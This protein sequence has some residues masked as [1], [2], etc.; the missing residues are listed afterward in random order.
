MFS[1]PRVGRHS[2]WV[3]GRTGFAL[4]QIGKHHVQE[5][6]PGVID[7]FMH[8]YNVMISQACLVLAFVTLDLRKQRLG[9]YLLRGHEQATLAVGGARIALDL[10][11]GVALVLTQCVCYGWLMVS[12]TVEGIGAD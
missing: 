12:V 11:F 8:A 9:C 1:L 4:Y 5:S 2:R 6:R 10:V 7:D 3:L